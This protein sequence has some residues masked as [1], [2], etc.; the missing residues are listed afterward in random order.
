MM[1]SR[2][3]PAAIN[4]PAETV[5]HTP[6]QRLSDRHCRCGIRGDHFAA[7]TQTRHRAERHE[8]DEM[9]AEADDFRLN[10]RI[11]G[12]RADVADFSECKIR[13]VRLDDLPDHSR[14]ASDAAHDIQRAEVCHERLAIEQ[15]LRCFEDFRRHGAPPCRSEAWSRSSRRACRSG[16]ARC[17]RR[18]ADHRRRGRE[19]RDAFRENPTHARR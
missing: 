13:P 6:A 16:F 19:S 9:I 15:I 3:R 14:D 11:A 4:R 5:E 12:V 10:R 17:S 8:L 7:G 18:A 2:Q 1:R